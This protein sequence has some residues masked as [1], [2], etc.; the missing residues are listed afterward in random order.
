M[1]SIEKVPALQVIVELEILGHITLY[2]I[3]EIVSVEKNV[4]TTFINQQIVVAVEA[5]ELERKYVLPFAV[6]RRFTSLSR[7]KGENA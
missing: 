2:E 5:R 6:H 3:M 7:S 4:F 1:L